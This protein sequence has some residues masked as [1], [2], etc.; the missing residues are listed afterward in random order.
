M[1]GPFCTFQGV[2]LQCGLLAEPIWTF[3]VTINTFI[4]IAGGPG[5]R[6]WAAEKSSSGKTRWILCFGIWAFVIFI[7]IFGLLFIEPLHPEKGNYCTLDLSRPLTIDNH[8]GAGW[9]WID[10]KYFWERIFFFY[11]RR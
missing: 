8:A 2:V 11:G 10:A 1:P 7:A 9:C 3:V 6:A 5:P 4:M